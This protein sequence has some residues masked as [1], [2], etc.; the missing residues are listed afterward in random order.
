MKLSLAASLANNL[1]SL[2]DRILALFRS[3]NASPQ[4]DAASCREPS[5]C[6]QRHLWRG[7][8]TPIPQTSSSPSAAPRRTPRLASLFPCLYNANYPHPVGIPHTCNDFLIRPHLRHYGVRIR[9][10]KASTLALLAMKGAA[11]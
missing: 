3:T 1:R 2:R 7:T 4:G 5:P 6:V 8:P 9:K 10:R 11:A